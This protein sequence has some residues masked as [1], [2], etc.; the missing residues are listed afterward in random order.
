MKTLTL[1]EIQIAADKNGGNFVFDT[2]W[3]LIEWEGGEYGY[4]ATE[5]KQP[6]DENGNDDF[7]SDGEYYGFEFFGNSEKM[8]LPNVMRCR[9]ELTKTVI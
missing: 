2:S 7:E 5:F 4:K 8:S 3:P 9:D 6:V 1:D